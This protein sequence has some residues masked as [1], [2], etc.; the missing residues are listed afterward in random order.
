MVMRCRRVAPAAR[1]ASATAASTQGAADAAADRQ[2]VEVTISQS[3]AIDG[4]GQQA[5]ALAVGLGDERRQLGR[6]VLAPAADDDP[7]PL[8]VEHA[9]RPRALVVAQRAHAHARA[10]GASSSRRLPNGSST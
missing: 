5:G 6:A 2:R 3:R 1:A 8:L 7:A 10:C 9:R 4:V